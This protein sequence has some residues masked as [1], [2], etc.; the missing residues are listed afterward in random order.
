[1][2]YHFAQYWIQINQT[3]F[4]KSVK[5]L[6]EVSFKKAFTI[7]S[8]FTDNI[9]IFCTSNPFVHPSS[10]LLWGPYC[11]FP[12]VTI[13]SPRFRIS[14]SILYHIYIYADLRYNAN[15][16]GH[17]FMVISYLTSLYWWADFITAVTGF[18]PLNYWN[19][20]FLLSW[21]QGCVGQLRDQQ[22]SGWCLLAGT[23]E[24]HRRTRRET[25]LRFLCHHGRRR[26]ASP[27]RSKSGVCCMRAGRGECWRTA[28][29]SGLCVCVCVFC[30]HNQVVQAV[31]IQRQG[32]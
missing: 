8:L 22:S 2:L 5:C 26:S 3:R 7:R 18:S 13:S 11:S 27:L 19:E 28:F 15:L 12:K 32:C 29:C 6:V 4:E 20:C 10:I 30:Y 21:C 16:L 17:P 24:I 23:E 25:W 14:E 31:V 9:S 1:M